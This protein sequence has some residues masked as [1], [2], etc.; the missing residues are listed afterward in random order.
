M[1]RWQSHNDLEAIAISCDVT[2]PSSCAGLYG[3]SGR[4]RLGIITTAERVRHLHAQFSEEDWEAIKGHENTCSVGQIKAILRQ[5]S[6]K[7]A[8]LKLDIHDAVLTKHLHV[9][10]D[11]LSQY[12]ESS[13]ERQSFIFGDEA[14]AASEDIQALQAACQKH[15]DQCGV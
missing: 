5:L 7:T 4:S 12:T 9:F 1:K 3:I 10:K 6:G 15:L 14:D 11:C 8:W 13:K 2:L